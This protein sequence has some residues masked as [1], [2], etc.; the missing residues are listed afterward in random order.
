MKLMYFDDFRLGV[1]KGDSVVDVTEVVKDIPHLSREDLLASIEIVG[2]EHLEEALSRGRGCI[3]AS[4]HLG[5]WE[6]GA[7]MIA[8]LGY[9]LHAVAGAVYRER[10]QPVAARGFQC[11]LAGA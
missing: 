11:H 4:S 1:V 10:A 6:L 5:N 9:T 8:Q 2:R 3:I 7:V